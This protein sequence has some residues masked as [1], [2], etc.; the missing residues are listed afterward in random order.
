MLTK[1]PHLSQTL[2]K[3]KDVVASLKK[4]IDKS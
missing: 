4:L 2:S 1:L 3:T